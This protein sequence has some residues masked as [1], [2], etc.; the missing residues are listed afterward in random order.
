MRYVILIIML[1]AAVGKPGCAS[2]A[3][4]VS[5]VGFF[6]RRN[7]FVGDTV[8]IT[9]PIDPAAGDGWRLTRFDSSIIRPQPG[10]G[11]IDGRRVTFRFTASTPGDAQVVFTRIR[12]ERATDEQRRF[13]VIV[14]SRL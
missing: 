2:N 12:R 4:Q 11:E 5:G 14:R 13:R 10:S 3:P 6:D 7:V 9:L 8:T 1:A